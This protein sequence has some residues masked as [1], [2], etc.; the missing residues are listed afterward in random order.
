MSKLIDRSQQYLTTRIL[1]SKSYEGLYKRR[2]A[3]RTGTP[4]RVITWTCPSSAR[5]DAIRVATSLRNYGQKHRFREAPLSFVNHISA[6]ADI[7]LNATEACTS[8]D[9]RNAYLHISSFLSGVLKYMAE[10]HVRAGTL[11]EAVQQRMNKVIQNGLNRTNSN[12]STTRGGKGGAASSTYSTDSHLWQWTRYDL[13]DDFGPSMNVELERPRSVVG[14][15]QSPGSANRIN[16]IPNSSAKRPQIVRQVSTP[17]KLEAHP[18]VSVED[19]NTATATPE[20]YS[21]KDDSSVTSIGEDT[22][23]R[24]V[25]I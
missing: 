21:I 10:V 19:L 18:E 15:I 24:R 2:S 4:Q 14:V 1:L 20:F 16:I 5:D 23:R 22:P 7:V 8:E 12:A 6:A 25:E 3:N 17:A 9:D 11:V 13:T